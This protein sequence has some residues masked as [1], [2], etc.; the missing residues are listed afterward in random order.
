MISTILETAVKEQLIPSNPASKATLPKVERKAVNYFEPEEVEQIIT[1]LESE[2]LKWRALT[3]VLIAS[4]C[5]RGECLGLKWINV[6]FINNR[7]YIENNIV[8]DPKH[9][10][11]ESTTKTE[12]AVR[13]INLPSYTMQ[14]LRDWSKQQ[15]EHIKKFGD[16]YNNQDFVFTRDNGEVIHP[17]SVTSWLNSF[18]K[19]H[20]L[21]HIN[22]H[23][24]RHTQAS[25]LVFAKVDDVSLASR[26]GHSNPA[27][28]KK[29]YAH[30]IQDA[31]KISAS[32]I[33]NAFR[34][35]A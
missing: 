13:W 30:L 8:Y 6:D 32:I 28:T 31:D 22:P 26:L 15:Q 10:V 33:E 29:Q 3:H 7:I 17:D 1:A 5:R 2:D 21:P 18:S 11:Y 25:I 14:Y 27:F 9:G 24:F 34:K 23:A 20:G 35:R 16:A 19:R 4:G 12:N